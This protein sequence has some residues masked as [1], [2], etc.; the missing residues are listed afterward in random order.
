[1]M[2]TAIDRFTQAETRV[3][4]LSTDLPDAEIAQA[5]AERTEALLQLL[6]WDEADPI[7]AAIRR[8]VLAQDRI[9]SLHDGFAN[10]RDLQPAE[11][12][13]EFDRADAER[14]E[15]I[16]ALMAA[17]PAEDYPTGTHRFYERLKK[18]ANAG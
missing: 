5:Y 6:R 12:D 4:D 17:P 14:E 3:Q 7:A 13:A 10:Y 16:L 11:W 2:S 1:M 18:L 15:A 8:L 9:Q